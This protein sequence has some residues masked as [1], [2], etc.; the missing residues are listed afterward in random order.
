[1]ASNKKPLPPKWPTDRYGNP[2]A[3][4][5]SRVNRPKVIQKKKFQGPRKEEWDK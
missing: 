2:V 4:F 3:K 1:M 5:N